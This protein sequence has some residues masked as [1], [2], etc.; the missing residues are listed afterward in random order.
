MWGVG[1]PATPLLTRRAGAWGE[2]LGLGWVKIRV[3]IRVRV[4]V[5]VRVRAYPLLR[6]SLGVQ[7]NGE[8]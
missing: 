5:R 4:T 2:G 8:G 3:R 7:V 1:R 6:S